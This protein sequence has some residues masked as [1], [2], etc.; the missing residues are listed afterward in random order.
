MSAVGAYG[1]ESVSAD[2]VDGSRDGGDNKDEEE[3]DKKCHGRKATLVL[4][5]PKVAEWT[6]FA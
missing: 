6:Q 2:E 5:R 1:A 3:K 4:I